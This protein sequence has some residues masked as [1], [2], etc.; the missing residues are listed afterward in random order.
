MSWTAALSNLQT[1]LDGCLLDLGGGK[2]LSEPA[3]AEMPV[4]KEP[5]NTD[6]AGSDNW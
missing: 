1:W 4:L 6:D 2:A 5:D 3:E